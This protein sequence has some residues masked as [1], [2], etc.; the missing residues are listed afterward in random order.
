MRMAKS[1]CSH[2]SRN[3]QRT[4]IIEQRVLHSFGLLGGEGGGGGGG[5][6]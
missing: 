3:G 1:E 2:F 4:S 5:A 6:S